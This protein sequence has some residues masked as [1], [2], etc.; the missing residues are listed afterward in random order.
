MEKKLIRIF[1]L[2]ASEGNDNKNS[3]KRLRCFV[4]NM[5]RYLHDPKKHRMLQQYQHWK[6]VHGVEN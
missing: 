1:E 2:Q 5:D 6:I 3:S 4:S